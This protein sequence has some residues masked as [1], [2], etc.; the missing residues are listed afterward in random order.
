MKNIRLTNAALLAAGICCSAA[1]APVAV[2]WDENVWEPWTPVLATAP[3]EGFHGRAVP[4]AR[5]TA[6]N[7]VGDE[8]D[9]TLKAVAWRNERVNGQFV[10]WSASGEKQLRLEPGD[11]VSASGG[12][13]PASAV[14]GRFVRYVRA[15]LV[16]GEKAIVPEQFVGDCLDTPD[17]TDTGWLDMP[18]NG[19]RPVWATINVPRDAAP[20]VYRG[21]LAVRAL[22]GK[23]L[24]FPIELTVRAETLADPADWSFF[25]DLWQHP[26]AVARYHHVKPFSAEHYSRLAPLL[27]ELAAAGQKTVTATITD[28]PW[29]HQNFDAYRTMIEH[30]KD[31]DGSW[32]HDYAVF[33]SWV[34]FALSCGLGPQIHCYTM[35]SWGNIV[36]YVDGASGDRVAVELKAGTSAHEAFWGPFLEDFE[37][38]LALKG[39]LGRTYIALDERSREELM[40]SANCIKRHAPR[41]KI[42]MAGNK[43]PSTFTGVDVD[44]YSSA[45]G[46]LTPEFIAEAADRRAKGYTTT[47]YICCGPLRPNT[48]ATSPL[49]EARWL[50]LFASAKGLDGMLRWA[51]FNWPRDPLLDTTFPGHRGRGSW[52]PGDTYLLYPDG[53][54]STR[55]EAFRDS[56]ENFEKIRQLRAAG[57]ASAELDAALATLA[58]DAGAATRPAASWAADADRVEAAIDACSAR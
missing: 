57:K 32:T 42:A 15:S 48:F 6:D 22:G 51:A 12:R 55:W 5:I 29:D 25:L 35:A 47:Y 1:A 53:R 8:S 20:G 56:I 27:K 36:Y 38:H 34:A 23:R 16:K 40:A 43:A 54:T 7:A 44:N 9:K 46:K 31:A 10:V 2:N 39:W 28:L 19:F 50:G 41:I 45:M 30:V 11:L 14:R 24:A 21:E 3:A 17:T 13:I 49:E 4:L 37:R 18:A 58:F 33:D 26:L 52:R